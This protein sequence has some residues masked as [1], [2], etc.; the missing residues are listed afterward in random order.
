[1]AGFSSANAGTP[2]LGEDFGGLTE[3]PLQHVVK[4][5]CFYHPPDD[6][7][8][9]K[10][11]QEAVVKRL[12]ASSRRN[13]LEFLLEIIPSKVGRVTIDTTP[14]IIQ[15]FYDVGVYPDWW[16]LEAFKTEAEWAATVDSIERND[17][18]TRGGVVV[19][20]GL[21]AP[22]AAELAASFAQ[23]AKFE[24]VKGFAVGRT[25]FGDAAR[26]WMQGHLTDAEAVS[27]MA[28]TYAGLCTVWDEARALKGGK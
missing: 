10:A 14:A 17:A 15:R 13:R 16:K 11:E 18:H 9:M 22:P 6:S 8:E 19:L 1:M 7:D 20:G 4:C 21:D 25:I 24:L 12:F 28:D 23:A 27:K 26:A 2:Q 5:L 3:W